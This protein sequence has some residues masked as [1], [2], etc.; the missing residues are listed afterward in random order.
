M[1]KR[2][3]GVVAL[4]AAALFLGVVPAHAVSANPAV[5]VVTAPATTVSASYVEW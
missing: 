5:T 2:L 3:F 4:G 1:L